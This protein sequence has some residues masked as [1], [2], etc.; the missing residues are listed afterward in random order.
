MRRAAGPD[1]K[2]KVFV[3]GEYWEAD[4]E[5]ALEVGDAVEVIAAKGLRVQ[6]K[7]YAGS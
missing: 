1:G 5:E 2:L 6:V 7:K 4:T 3:H